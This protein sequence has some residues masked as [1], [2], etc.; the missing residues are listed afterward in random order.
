MQEEAVAAAER[1]RKCKE[2]HLQHTESIKAEFGAKI[3][4]L[5]DEH[6]KNLEDLRRRHRPVSSTMSRIFSCPNM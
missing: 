2:E 4:A 5:D 3:K 6:R 1:L